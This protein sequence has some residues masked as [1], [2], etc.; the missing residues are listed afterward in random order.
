[1]PLEAERRSPFIA[2]MRLAKSAA[3]ADAAITRN[4]GQ[5]AARAAP[6]RHY[7]SATFHER[8]EV[9]ALGAEYDLTRKAWFVPAGR[10]LAPFKRWLRG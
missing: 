9:K 10:D 7:L 1:M 4:A 2:R 5:Q 8:M 3:A 6:A